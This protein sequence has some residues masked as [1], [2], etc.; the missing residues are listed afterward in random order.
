MEKFRIN[1]LILTCLAIFATASSCEEKEVEYSGI[2]GAYTCIEASSHSGYRN[3]IIEID[4]VNNQD[5]LF[6]ILNFHNTGANEFLYA[7]YTGDSI[8][9]TDQ[10]SGT[11]FI[12]GSGKVFS[13]FRR[14]EINYM[15]DDGVT[16]LDYQAVF[17]R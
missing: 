17:E 4:K 6:I 9:I 1:R 7:E 10:V 16:E 13:D 12:N 14:M 8:Y 2:E 5:G 11:L 3:Y 15:T